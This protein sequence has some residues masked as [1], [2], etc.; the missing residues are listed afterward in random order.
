MV[1]DRSRPIRRSRAPK[2]IPAIAVAFPLLTA[3]LASAQLGPDARPPRSLGASD[4]LAL[5]LFG[6]RELVTPGVTAQA[7]ERSPAPVRDPRKAVH[8][9][10]SRWDSSERRP[11]R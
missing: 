6:D 1:R 11:P 5:V 7:Q 2:L 4:E 10:F 8:D 3:P 9:W